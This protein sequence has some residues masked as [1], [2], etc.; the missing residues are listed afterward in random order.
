M[1]TAWIRMKRRVTRRLTRI[2]AV[3]HP[4]NIFIIL[5]NIEAIWKLKQASLEDG[6]LFCGLRVNEFSNSL[7]PD[8]KRSY[9]VSDMYMSISFE[10]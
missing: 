4:D 8:Q 10:R 5:S 9:S 1:Q 3:G 2:E 6:T 7:D